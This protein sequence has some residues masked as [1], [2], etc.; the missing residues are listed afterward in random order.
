MEEAEKVEKED[1]GLWIVTNLSPLENSVEFVSE[2]RSSLLR[3]TIHTHTH[4]SAN[5]HIQ[6][7]N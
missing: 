5:K 1:N 4:S 7:F 2:K 3:W 6:T